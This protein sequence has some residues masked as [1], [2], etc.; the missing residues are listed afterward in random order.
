VS[1]IEIDNPE[2]L[3]EREEEITSALE[4]AKVSGD[5]LFAAL[6]VTDVTMLDSLL[7]IAGNKAFTALINFPSA[8]DGVYELKGVVSRKKQLMPLL[9]ELMLQ[10]TA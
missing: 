3:M 6:L 7:F 5:H 2:A 9:T 8:S 10:Y 4:K 1:Q